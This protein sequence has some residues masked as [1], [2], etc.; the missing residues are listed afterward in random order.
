ML[1][2]IEQ[3]S[4]VQAKIAEG[5]T[6]LNQDPLSEENAERVREDLR[7]ALELN[8]REPAALLTASA[9]NEKRK[10][11]TAAGR[12]RGTLVEV[13]P[14]EARA[15]AGLGH[16]LLLA[17]EYAK[18]EEA[19]KRA[20]ELERMTPQIAE[21]LARVHQAQKDDKGALPYLEEALK[22]DAKRQDLWFL[23]AHAAEQAGDAALA[24][25]SFEQGLGLGGVH[26]SEC[27]DLLR[28]YLVSNQD[29]KAKELERTTIAGL[30]AGAEVRAEFAGV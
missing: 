1:P 30:P 2:T 10:D 29:D 4:A 20:V 28:L 23:K 21:D 22:G 3:Y 16:V 12:L 13:R 18:A 15:Y 9:Y 26:I 6:L 14:L 27:G 8:G 5:G 7:A 24:M 19:L 11:Y 17:G 25:Q